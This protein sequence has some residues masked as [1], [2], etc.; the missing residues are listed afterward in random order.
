MLFMTKPAMVIDTEAL[1]RIGLEVDMR[2]TDVWAMLFEQGDTPPDTDFLG[3]L[4]RLSYVTGY[5]DA[6]SESDR[7]ELCG[8]LGYPIPERRAAATDDESAA[9]ATSSLHG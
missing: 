9:C 4:L 7:G 6:L 8:Q 3:W 2:L 5:W 1:D